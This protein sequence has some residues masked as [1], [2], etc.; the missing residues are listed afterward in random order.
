M[1][2]RNRTMLHIV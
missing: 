1:L 2:E